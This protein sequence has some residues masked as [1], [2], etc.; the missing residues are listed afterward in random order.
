[1][2]LE[3]LDATVP[4]AGMGESGVTVA[5]VD[6]VVRRTLVAAGDE[7]AT[8]GP[9][10][11]SPVASVLGERTSSVLGVTGSGAWQEAIDAQ[12]DL[13]DFVTPAFM[14]AEYSLVVLSNRITSEGEYL[15]VRRPGRGVR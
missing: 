5:G 15:K 11:R 7:L 8:A 2:N 13:P 9:S 14:Q 12:K 6:A 3:L 4:Q 1:N 10:G